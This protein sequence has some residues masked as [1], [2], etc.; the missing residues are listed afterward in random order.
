MEGGV[1]TNLKATAVVTEQERER[2][3]SR[4]VQQKSHYWSKYCLKRSVLRQFGRRGGKGC[5]GERKEE[6]PDLDSREAKGKD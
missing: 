4:P 2:E 1:K 3:S 5:D 6:N